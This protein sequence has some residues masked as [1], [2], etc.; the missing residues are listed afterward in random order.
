MF[1]WSSGTF[2]RTI[3]TKQR[4]AIS[5]RLRRICRR[6]KRDVRRPGTDGSLA[7]YTEEMFALLAHGS[8]PLRRLRKMCT[9]I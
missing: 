5:K 8:L 1:K 7:L 9:C 2:S 4:I 6:G 3:D